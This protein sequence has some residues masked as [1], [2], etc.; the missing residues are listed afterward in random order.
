MSKVILVT[1]ASSGFGALTAKA[2][3]AAGHTVYAGMHTMRDKESHEAEGE[4]PIVMDVVSDESVS[5]GVEHIVKNSGRL[6]VIVHNAGHMSYGPAEA[7]TPAQFASLYDI[8]VLGTQRLNR[9]ALPHMRRSRS[10][11]LIWIGSTST[12]GG[13]PPFLSPYFAA[14]AA[15]D[16]LAESYASELTLWGIDT[17]I[18]VPGA[19]TGGTSHF[20]NAGKPEDQGVVES[21]LRKG[22]CYEGIDKRVLDGLAG[23]EPEG[24]DGGIGERAE[25]VPRACGSE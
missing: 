1:G 15:M 17:T 21:Y 7:F 20:A 22:G 13:H 4:I 23:L 18:V 19:F 6:D 24:A 3:A 12:R 25:A 9:A 14:K 10:G 11:L 5:T 16:S 2:L 8:N